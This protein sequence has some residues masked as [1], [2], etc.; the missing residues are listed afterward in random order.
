MG[1]EFLPLRPGENGK[2]LRL[3]STAQWSVVSVRMNCRWRG[4]L[5][6]VHQGG[7]LKLGCR[8][9]ACALV[10]RGL[11]GPQFSV[12]S[13][14]R[15]CLCGSFWQALS[16][17]LGDLTCSRRGVNTKSREVSPDHVIL[18]A[19]LISPQNSWP[20]SGHHYNFRS[21]I[22]NRWK[23]T[24]RFISD[25][26]IELSSPGGRGSDGCK[27]SYHVGV[28]PHLFFPQHM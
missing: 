19:P 18:G 8:S 3:K 10:L 2:D 14:G 20:K 17:G 23:K 22:I 12:S 25:Q 5:S 13:V 16:L 1:C 15:S 21:M 9:F 24:H 11:G 7:S 4:L 26:S 6:I 28:L 27:E